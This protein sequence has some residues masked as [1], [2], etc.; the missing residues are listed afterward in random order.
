MKKKTPNFHQ[1]RLQHPHL[2]FSKFP[3][4]KPGHPKGFKLEK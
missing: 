2:D 4:C 3:P 1:K